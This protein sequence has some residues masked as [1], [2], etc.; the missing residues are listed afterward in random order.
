M[1]T[2]ETGRIPQLAARSRLGQAQLEQEHAIE[3]YQ[4][5][6]TL[7]NQWLQSDTLYDVEGELPFGRSIFR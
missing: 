4:I 1:E 2:G 7:F 3:K 5:A 6:L